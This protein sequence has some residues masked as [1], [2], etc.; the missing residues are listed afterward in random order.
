MRLSGK[1]LCK[2]SVQIPAHVH[3]QFEISHSK[4]VHV[5]FERIFG[6][7]FWVSK[8]SVDCCTVVV[9]RCSI[10]THWHGFDESDNYMRGILLIKIK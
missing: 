4:H 5:G 3:I 9:D 10:D 6:S 1:T 2:R 7:A 8:S